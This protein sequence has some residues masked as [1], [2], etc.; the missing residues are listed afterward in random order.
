MLIRDVLTILLMMALFLFALHP[1]AHV[2]GERRR[3]TE[4]VSELDHEVAGL[5]RHLRYDAEAH[6]DLRAAIALFQP[7][8]G[9]R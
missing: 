8:G 1:H 2:H 9:A 3:E 7:E 4:S 6:E 5:G